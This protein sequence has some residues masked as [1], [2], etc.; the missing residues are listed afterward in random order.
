MRF[1]EATIGGPRLS[2]YHP[3]VPVMFRI[4]CKIPDGVVWFVTVRD[5]RGEPATPDFWYARETRPVHR[6]PSGVGHADPQTVV[7]ACDALPGCRIRPI[8]RGIGE[9]TYVTAPNTMI[10]STLMTQ[11]RIVM[12]VASASGTR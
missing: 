3:F 9:A 5:G 11:S 12:A 7:A 1:A 6:V 4:A 10:E 8:P 2:L